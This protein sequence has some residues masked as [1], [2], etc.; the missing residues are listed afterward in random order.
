MQ[1][2]IEDIKANEGWYKFMAIIVTTISFGSM[3]IN[4]IK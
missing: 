2:L 1:K 4:L 3:I